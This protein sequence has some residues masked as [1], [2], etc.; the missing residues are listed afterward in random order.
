MWMGG[1]DDEVRLWFARSRDEGA[2]WSHPVAVTP[3]GEPLRIH[4][5]A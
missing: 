5:E 1:A 4:A 3:P 2:S